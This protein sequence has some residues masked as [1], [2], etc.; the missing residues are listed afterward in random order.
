MIDSAVYNNIPFEPVTGRENIAENIASF[1][2]PGPPGVERIEFRVINIAAN[3]PA[4]LTERID[5]FTL[6]ARLSTCKSWGP[7]R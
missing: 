4:V 3:G 7:S 6:A 1:I 5:V 2:R